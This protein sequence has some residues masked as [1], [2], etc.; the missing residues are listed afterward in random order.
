MMRALYIGRFQPYHRGHQLVLQKISE[1]VAEIVI[2]IGSA[3]ES[4]SLEN[5]F[6]AGERIAMIYGALGG[7]RNRC[8]VIPLHDVKRNAVWV[9]HLISMVPSFD[10]VYSNNSLVTQLFSEAGVAIRKPPLFRREVYSGTAIRNLML[11]GG[12]W[13]SL[14]PESVASVIEEIDGINR[15]ANV[16]KSDAGL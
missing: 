7:L 11:E 15:L 9:S 5:P 16:S 3:Q 6:T 2:V 4:H 14:V 1:E 12:D 8:Y 10:I 13:R